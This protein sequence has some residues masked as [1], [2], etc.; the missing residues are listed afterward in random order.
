[1][2]RARLRGEAT[3]RAC[4]LLLP[5]ALY[6][7][8]VASAVRFDQAELPRFSD[9][10]EHA[11]SFA[12]LGALALLGH[13]RRSGLRAILPALLAWGLFIE[14]VQYGLPWRELSLLDWAADGAGVVLA[15]VALR[16]L[17]RTDTPA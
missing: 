5:L 1:M 8:L 10:I 3:R 2:L 9:K 11:I 14:C 4:A 17:A 13:P 15:I 16:P 12:L 6:A 7:V